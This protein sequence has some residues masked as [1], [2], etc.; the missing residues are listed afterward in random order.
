M[1]QPRSALVSVSETPYYHVVSHCVQKTFPER[2][3]MAAQK[4]IFSCMKVCVQIYYYSIS[5]SYAFI[6]SSLTSI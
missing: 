1:P 3:F 2:L 5:L 6:I 4:Q